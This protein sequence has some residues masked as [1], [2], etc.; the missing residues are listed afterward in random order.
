ML[1]VE[2]TLPRV[3][4]GRC[5]E[6]DRRVRVDRRGRAKV[7]QMDERPA[8][9]AG[10]AGMR[11][12]W[13]AGRVVG[14]QRCR[15]CFRCPGGGARDSQRGAA[16]EPKRSGRRA[17]HPRHVGAVAVRSSQ[18][19]GCRP[20]VPGVSTWHEYRRCRAR[21]VSHHRLGR[22]R[23]AV[24]RL[25]ALWVARVR[26]TGAVECACLTLSRRPASTSIRMAHSPAEVACG[27]CGSVDGL[28]LYGTKL[29]SRDVV[30][31]RCTTCDQKES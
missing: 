16:Y 13:K 6:C 24:R 22:R 28:V 26:S 23:G 18:G 8:R 12:P 11:R 15:W 14:W 17:V 29:K 1:K 30:F 4:K 10:A 2:S 7:A 5:S 31:V 21:V 19:A 25:P 9:P 27:I 20:Y 3:E